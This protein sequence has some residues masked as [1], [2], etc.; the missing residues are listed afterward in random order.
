MTTDP[1]QPS[2]PARGPRILEH[3][4]DPQRRVHRVSPVSSTTLLMA[5]Y[6]RKDVRYTSFY[7][8]SPVKV[9][10]GFQLRW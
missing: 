4:E 1:P 3:K 5:M 8:V 10:Y 6:E 7:R 2:P 9:E